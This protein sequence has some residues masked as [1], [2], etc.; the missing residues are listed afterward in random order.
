[1]QIAFLDHLVAPLL[2]LEARQASVFAVVFMLQSIYGHAKG[3]LLKAPFDRQ[4]SI[5]GRHILSK[6]VF[7]CTWGEVSGK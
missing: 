3:L 4:F 2:G 1:V 5:F 7:A 6:K